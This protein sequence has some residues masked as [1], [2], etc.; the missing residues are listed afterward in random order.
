M[1]V[2]FF[3]TDQHHADCLGFMGH[4]LVKTPN[5]DALAERGAWFRNMFSCSAICAPSRTS[6][7][8]GTYL[9]THEHFTN[10]GDLHRPFPSIASEYRNAGHRAGVCGKVHI[11]D[12]LMR[13]FDSVDPMAN[14]RAYLE[15]RGLREVE[16]TKEFHQKFMSA[17]SPVSYKDHKVAWTADRAID[18]L[19]AAK[20]DE[21]S[22]FLWCS[23]GPPHAPHTPPAEMDNLYNPE[24]IPIDW[25]A[26][27]RFERSRVGQRA[28]I[29]DFWKVG[30]VRHDPSIFQKAVCRYLALI[31][32]VDREIGRV[33]ERLNALGLEEET[34]VIFTA[35]HGDF[36]GHWG[37]LGKN[38]PGYDDLLRIPFIYY[39]PERADHGRCVEGLY[40]NVDLFPS[41]CERLNRDI[42]PTVQGESFLPAL[43]GYPGASRRYVYAETHNVKTIRSHGWKLNFY[44]VHP[45]R[46]QLFRMGADPDETA[47]LWTDPNYAHIKVELMQELIAWMV[48]CEQADGME[49][50]A[51]EFVNTRWYRWLAQQPGQVDDQEGRAHAV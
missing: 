6:F 19:N 14:Y 49:I 50:K 29:E 46:G 2:L 3:M 48:Q 40:Q 28:M 1:N 25:E 15:E 39:D 27:E 51:E 35:D 36:A 16:V 20:K 11:P 17:P 38:V 5:L 41:L 42:P 37:Q 8:T 24:D 32:T 7:L 26:Y 43:E 21:T 31:T 13:H 45:N 30:S 23:F 10:P 22:F 47:N 18:F 9:R 33:L 44:G 34:L 12:R 4:P